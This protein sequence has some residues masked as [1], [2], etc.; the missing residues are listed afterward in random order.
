MNKQL[1]GSLTQEQIIRFSLWKINRD[2]IYGSIFISFFILM[3][4]CS[5]TKSLLFGVISTLAMY[6]FCIALIISMSK[7]KK[8][9][10]E[11]FD[12]CEEQN[13]K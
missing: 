11:F 7:D 1:K 5:I 10:K 12:S 2:I 6:V 13:K 9:S 8:I 3:L 4:I